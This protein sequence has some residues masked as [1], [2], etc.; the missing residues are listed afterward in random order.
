MEIPSQVRDLL[1]MGLRL[2]RILVQ[3]LLLSIPEFCRLFILLGRVPCLGFAIVC[4]E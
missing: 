3:Y 4:M 2:E 1:S